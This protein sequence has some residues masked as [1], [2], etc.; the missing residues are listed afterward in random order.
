MKLDNY[1][2]EKELIKLFNAEIDKINA[3]LEEIF[4]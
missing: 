3:E 4:K 1:K 2:Y